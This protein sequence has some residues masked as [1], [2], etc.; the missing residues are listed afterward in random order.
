M[1]KRIPTRDDIS[2]HQLKYDLLLKERAFAAEENL[3]KQD[4]RRSNSRLR[5]ID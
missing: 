5:G 3:F 4:N 1:K 2:R